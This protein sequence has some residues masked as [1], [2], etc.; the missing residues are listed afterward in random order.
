[1]S[2]MIKI[3]VGISL[4]LIIITYILNKKSYDFEKQS[5]YECGIEP[6]EENQISINNIKKKEIKET[7]TREKFY[8]KFY[9][10]GIIFLIF[11][12]ES[13]LLYPI[14]FSPALNRDYP[15]LISSEGIWG[16]ISLLGEQIEI[17]YIIFIIFMSMLIIGLIYEYLKK[18]LN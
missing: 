10:I 3:S 8:I 16:G 17:S 18:V 9:I 7:E 1:M 2:I 5:Q 12:L 6:F 15:T 11:D 4:I 14:I 13:L